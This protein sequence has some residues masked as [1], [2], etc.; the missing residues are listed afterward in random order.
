MAMLPFATRTDMFEAIKMQVGGP[1]SPPKKLKPIQAWLDD[2]CLEHDVPGVRGQL[3]SLWHAHACKR[4]EEGDEPVAGGGP[5]ASAE[6][7]TCKATTPPPSPP[8]WGRAK[9]GRAPSRGWEH[10]VQG[11]HPACIAASLRPSEAGLFGIP[12]AP[13][14]FAIN[15]MTQN[16][17]P[18]CLLVRATDLAKQHSGQFQGQAAYYCS[19]LHHYYPL[20]GHYYV[21]LHHYYIYYYLFLLYYY[22]V[23]T[24]L[25]PIIT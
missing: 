14:R 18:L 4:F 17:V 15:D 20:K 25:L 23:I 13:R 12:A 5:R 16:H 24:S 19:L 6:L 8:R 21:L 22:F 3:K 9:L 7:M 10:D 11:H 1:T 2:L